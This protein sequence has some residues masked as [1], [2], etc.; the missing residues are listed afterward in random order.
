MNRNFF[1]ILERSGIRSKFG[2]NSLGLLGKVLIL[3]TLS[4]ERAFSALKWCEN[5]VLGL[6]RGI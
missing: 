1:S 3:V 5:A 4:A 2:R 6:F